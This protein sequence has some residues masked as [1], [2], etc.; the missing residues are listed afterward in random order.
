MKV[1][2][3]VALYNV[4][5]YAD[6]CIESLVKQSYKDLE[7]ILV[8][9]GSKDETAAIVDKWA[10]QDDRIKA[11]HQANGG[12]SAAR[13]TGMANATGECIAFIDGDDSVKENYFE[14]LVKNMESTGA[15]MTGVG[16]Y[17]N[18]PGEDTFRYFSSVDSLTVYN[19][20][21]DYMYDIY[22]DKD[23]RFFQSGIVVWGKIYKRGIWD[24]IDFPVGRNNEDSWVFPRVMTRC[25]KIAISPDQL[26]FY[27][28]R[29]GSIMSNVNE[30]LVFS[31]IDSWM[32]QI[33]FWRN[34]KDS[35]AEELLSICEKY[36]C[37]YIYTNAEYMDSDYGKKLKPEYKAMVRHILST[38]YLSFKTKAKYLT[39]ARTGK[40]FK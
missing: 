39:F 4:K 23:K 21:R 13:N 12:L 5:D 34:S 6:E 10:A 20:P 26:Y 32:S 3:V 2:V 40:I 22:S 11:I 16:R 36:I 37:H 30:K 19:D 25:K 28:K 29:S 33:N 35:R 8:D 9:D 24:G 27:R 31:K 15:D 38:K 7:I 18:V 17:E 1:S 14:V